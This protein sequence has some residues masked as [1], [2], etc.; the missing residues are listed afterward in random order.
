MHWKSGGGDTM[1]K[2]I[3]QDIAVAAS[4]IIGYS[5][6]ITG[7]DSIVLGAT[8][9]ERIGTLHEASVEVI[10]TG[11]QAV[12]DEATAAALRGT[13]P[14]TTMPIVIGDEVV[15]T[16]GISGDPE[17]VA[18]YGLLIKMM[19]GVFLRDRLE[20]D[21]ARMREERRQN[22][23]REIVT[24]DERRD[25]ADGLLNRGQ[26][27]GYDLTL[28]RTAVLI[29]LEEP[30]GSAEGTAYTLAAV[31]GSADYRII[32]EAYPDPQDIAVIWRSCHYL[33]F[34]CAG[35]RIG[36]HRHSSGER[37]GENR[38]GPGN[39]GR[40]NRP[41]GTGLQD[42]GKRAQIRESLRSKNQKLISR[43]EGNG[44]RIAVGIGNPAFGAAAMRK[45]Y[46]EADQALYIAGNRGESCCVCSDD[47]FIEKLVMGLPEDVYRDFYDEKLGRILAEKNSGELMDLIVCWCESKF[48]F[49][50]T[51]R[52][53]N[54]HK[55]TLDY[56]FKRAGCI[57]GADLQN[58]RDALALY[59]VVMIYR[60][61]G[62]K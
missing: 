33:V 23:L 60:M 5:V 29:R 47:I 54:V 50:Q 26:L 17:D 52:L 55:N 49:A 40:Q 9:S 22:L 45:S 62:T 42:D 18:R 16:I 6:L 32:K 51:A 59:I 13:R 14:G 2:H 27:L 12:H 11:R 43:L 34:T 36:E 58:F 4:N 38:Y 28:A 46:Q 48:N 30:E 7:K 35:E 3:A 44:R 31:V 25:N 53:L 21:S 20:V 39:G 61:K 41:F 37:I 19:A 24:F 15:G 1:L 56:R 57:L 8:N 10:R